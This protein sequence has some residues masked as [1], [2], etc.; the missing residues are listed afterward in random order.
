MS[1]Q[2]IPG[3]VRLEIGRRLR[4][5][6]YLCDIA[7]SCGVSE[8]YVRKVAVKEGIDYARCKRGS[9]WGMMATAAPAAPPVEKNYR[10]A[11]TSARWGN[12]WSR[13]FW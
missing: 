12:D 4:D 7:R 6:Q 10:G 13:G 11:A 1:K 8:G 9:R 5:G 3:T 2:Q